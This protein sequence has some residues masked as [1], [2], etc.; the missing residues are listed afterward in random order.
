MKTIG[1]GQ[2]R[3]QELNNDNVN[4]V[5]GSDPD[6]FVPTYMAVYSLVYNYREKRD[7]SVFIMTKGDYPE[8]YKE[9]LEKLSETAKGFALSF[10]FINMEELYS[11]V[12]FSQARLDTPTMYRLSIPNLL[13]DIDRCLYLDSDITVE[14]NIG[15]LYDMDLGGN[16]ILGVKDI[17]I[18]DNTSYGLEEILGI[19]STD[20]YVNAGVLLMDLAGIRAEGLSGL[21]EEEGRNCVYPS[22][23]QDVINK[24]FYHRIGVIPPRYNAVLYYIDRDIP[25]LIVKYGAEEYERAKKDPLVVHYL[26]NIKPWKCR[27]F[28]SGSYWWKYAGMQD[29]DFR[30]DILDPYVKSHRV[31][32]KLALKEW[33]KSV[34]V[35]LR[36][37]RL[38]VKIIGDEQF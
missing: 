24:L 2:G 8:R 5:F 1:T 12:K 31:G 10:T 30:K 22:Y 26:L 11:G 33:L 15:E 20:R 7:L 32:F 4:I 38:A 14:G 18:A 37:Y 17:H 3:I 21:M 35:T 19:P 29:R 13:K 27:R 9:E 34:M 25:A 28:I 23:D 16:L 6:Y 36:L